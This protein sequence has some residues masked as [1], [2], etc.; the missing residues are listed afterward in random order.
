MKSILPAQVVL[1]NST[2]GYRDPNAAE[3]KKL[4]ATA[5][6]IEEDENNTNHEDA[7]TNRNHPSLP[8]GTISLGIPS[9]PKHIESPHGEEL[10]QDPGQS[11]YDHDDPEPRL[12]RRRVLPNAHPTNKDTRRRDE[13]SI[14]EYGPGSSDTHAQSNLHGTKSSD[15]K[16]GTNGTDPYS[17]TSFKPLEH[18]QD[19]SF[20]DNYDLGV[21][22]PS[23]G[24]IPTPL[25]N[26]M[27]SPVY[28]SLHGSQG[29]CPSTSSQYPAQYSPTQPDNDGSFRIYDF[30]LNLQPG[31]HL[32][33]GNPDWD[34]AA[35]FQSQEVSVSYTPLQNEPADK[36]AEVRLE[37]GKSYIFICLDTAK[38]TK[39]VV[40][41]DGDI[42][43][44]TLS[45]QSLGNHIR[46]LEDEPPLCKGKAVLG[47]VADDKLES[48]EEHDHTELQLPV[49]MQYII[50]CI[51]NRR[52]HK[53][54]TVEG[55]ETPWDE[56]GY[57]QLVEGIENLGGDPTDLHNASSPQPP[58]AD[59]DVLSADQQSNLASLSSSMQQD[60]LRE[61]QLPFEFQYQAQDMTNQANESDQP[62]ETVGSRILPGHNPNIEDNGDATDSQGLDYGKFLEKS[63]DTEMIPHDLIEKIQQ[64]PDD[65]LSRAV[66]RYGGS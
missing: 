41:A 31:D 28:S 64:I 27:T 34:I 32:I 18:L 4:L 38:A 26:S 1:A 42:A 6:S 23:Q 24:T 43:P 65:L 51:E 25:G 11:S 36:F 55:L 54:V 56:I 16:L 30:D 59:F 21:S 5:G 17:V 10:L 63:S 37:H 57:N 46:K 44:E 66:F 58:V 62:P 29:L 33:N 40:S 7:S 53:A 52:F 22:W 19:Q 45:L 13:K 39:C 3:V 2:Y 8:P 61:S 12:K 9:R 15:D 50:V 48:E 35:P 14:R 60:Q 49:E 47:S 20:T